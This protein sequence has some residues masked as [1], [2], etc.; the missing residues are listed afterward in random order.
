MSLFETLSLG[1]KNIGDKWL[2][3]RIRII[4]S[5]V[6]IVEQK[7]EYFMKR[8]RAFQNVEGAGLN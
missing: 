2:W 6:L 7:T 4:S 5:A 3:K 1:H 8:Y